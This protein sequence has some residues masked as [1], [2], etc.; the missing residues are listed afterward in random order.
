MGR[1]PGGNPPSRD[2][3]VMPAAARLAL[4][5]MQL[6]VDRQDPTVAGTLPGRAM[7]IERYPILSGRLCAGEL[8]D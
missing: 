2:L 8:G 7:G 6:L 5:Q 4:F 1:A 3:P